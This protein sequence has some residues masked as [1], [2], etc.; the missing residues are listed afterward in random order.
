MHCGTPVCERD[1]ITHRMDYFGPVVNRSARICARAAGGQI[2]CSA[3]VVREINAKVLGTEPETEYSPLQTPQAIEA[4]NQI[5]IELVPV[6]E[7]KLK[8]L[9]I[10]ET[11]SIAYPRALESRKD[12]KDDEPSERT[13]RIQFSVEQM[14]QLELLALRLE[15]LSSGR[16]FRPTPERRGSTAGLS[17]SDATSFESY[18]ISGDPQLLL[19]PINDKASD[20]DLMVLLD[21]LSLRI[22]NSLKALAL[23]HLSE[24]EGIKRVLA[25]LLSD[26][27]NDERTSRALLS[28]FDVS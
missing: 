7:V 8:G 13:S 10:P 4:I 16:V 1:P 2:M 21:S 27:Q 20:T 28:L 3:D 11:L 26:R 5:G 12:L 18:I 9:E 23:R 15:A 19:P 6:G 22:E 24:D 14:R 17:P 25:S